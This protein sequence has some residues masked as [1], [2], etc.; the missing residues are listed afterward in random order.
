MKNSKSKF[1]A[2]VASAALVATFGLAACGGTSSSSAA[3][4]AAS[5]SATA[6]SAATSESASSAATSDSA[7]SAA[8]SASASAADSVSL[9]ALAEEL[10]QN[11]L[12]GTD[13]KNVLYFYAQGEDN[14]TAALLVYD[15]TNDAFSAHSGTYEEPTVGTVRIDTKGAGEAIEFKVVP[16]A[17]KTAVAFTFD[18]GTTVN[19]GPVVDEDTKK[20][21]NEL[22]QLMAQV[23]ASEET[24]SA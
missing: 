14:K 21:L 4:S 10:F 7:S 3:S 13:D 1:L 16:N 9:S 23:N 22:D 17:D 19:M 5:G 6:S 8:A 11:C 15:M 24:P 2:L 18:N 20:M 12:V